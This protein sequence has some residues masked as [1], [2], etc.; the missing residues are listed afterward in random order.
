MD[1][2]AVVFTP[3][4]RTISE[5]TAYVGFLVALA[6]FFVSLFLPWASIPITI[7]GQ[8]DVS[9][10]GWA[11]QAYLSVLP[12]AGLF[13]NGLPAR[14]PLTLNISVL[15]VLLAFALLFVDNVDHRSLWLTPLLVDAGSTVPHAIYGSYLDSGFWF[16]LASM[17]AL[18]VFGIAWTMHRTAHDT[19]TAAIAARAA[20]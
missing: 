11:E 7:A 4:Q 8:G 13:L 15:C 17:V 19:T 2:M 14:K 18:S 5:R 10:S 12:F 16:A 1:P 20:G 9:A 6:M 3:L